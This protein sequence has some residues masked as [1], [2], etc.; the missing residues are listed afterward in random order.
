MKT[1]GRLAT[2]I[3]A[4]VF[5]F[6]LAPMATATLILSEDFEG[7]SNEFG[8]STTAA[9]N[10]PSGTG[11]GGSNVAEITGTTDTDGNLKINGTATPNVVFAPGEDTIQIEF[12]AA[13]GQDISLGGFGIDVIMRYRDSSTNGTSAWDTVGG[14]TFDSSS[15]E[16]GGFV[17]QTIETTPP[18]GFDEVNKV[19]LEFVA[20]ADSETEYTA[21]VDNVN[22][23]AIP[24]PASVALLGLGGLVIAGGRRRSV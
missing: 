1:P 17:S 21:Y 23:T 9:S 15:D 19:R 18:A 7:G 14:Y 2:L 22:V 20:S 5:A 6:A 8:F 16:A 4:T 3:A 24:E 12:G 13:L 10:A 11:S